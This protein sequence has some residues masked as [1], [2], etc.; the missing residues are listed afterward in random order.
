MS[1]VK[2]VNPDGERRREHGTVVLSELHIDPDVQR[3]EGID[4]RRVSKMAA[5][6]DPDALGVIIV[7]R[8]E[9]GT[10]VVLDGMHRCATAREAKWKQPL[11]AIIY[12]GLSREDEAALFLRYNN[13]KDPSAVSK[14]RARLVMGEPVAVDIAAT[15]ARHGWEISS[16]G[17]DGYAHAATAIEAA[18]VKGSGSL[19]IGTYPAVLDKTFGALTAAWGHDEVSAHQHIVAGLSQL[20]GRFGDQVDVDKLVR[21]MQGTTP[22]RLVGQAKALRDAQGGTVPAALAKYLTAMHNRRK[23]TG[24]LPEWIWTR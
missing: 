21:E 1:A 14:F 10:L 7:S 20:F 18:Y 4:N 5:D 19:K 15:L 12:S 17:G 9:D 11:E 6:F 13:K 23:R 24:L 16:N 2:A 22:R 3:E 8:R